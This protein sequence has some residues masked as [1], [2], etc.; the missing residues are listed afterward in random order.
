MDGVSADLWQAAM[1]Q[2]FLQLTY[3]GVPEGARG[4]RRAV[5]SACGWQRHF[6][7]AGPQHFIERKGGGEFGRF[8]QCNHHICQVR[9]GFA[10]FPTEQ[11]GPAWRI[12]MWAA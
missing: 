4:I 7:D 12:G 9:N 11:A 8:A 5:T 10:V 1:L 2:P 6:E 3:V